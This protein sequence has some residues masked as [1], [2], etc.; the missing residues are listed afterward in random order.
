[1]TQ[2][3]FKSESVRLDAGGAM[4]LAHYQSIA[5]AAQAHYP[6]LQAIFAGESRIVNPLS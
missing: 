2:P 4:L 3:S 6:F 5:K 1:M